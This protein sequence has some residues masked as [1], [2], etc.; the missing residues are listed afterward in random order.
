MDLT[1]TRVLLFGLS[2]AGVP[3]LVFAVRLITGAFAE[4]ILAEVPYTKKEASFSIVTPGIY[5]IWQKA[6]LFNKTPIGEF[7][8]EVRS[9]Q[10]DQPLTLRPSLMRQSVNNG[11]TGRMELFK[12][13]APAGDYRIALVEGSSVSKIELALSKLLPI[14]K[15]A[16]P[17]DYFLQVTKARS[18]FV[19]L[20][21]IFL[22]LIAAG[23]I[24]G[25]LVLGFL[26]HQFVG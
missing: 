14:G 17:A 6:P 1:L 10:S 8:P 25:G 9:S 5:A 23:S 19:L 12:F 24:L 20:S 16:A 11:L 21:G 26:A 2:L 7:R 18:P 15:T 22:T 3:L 13:F 4:K